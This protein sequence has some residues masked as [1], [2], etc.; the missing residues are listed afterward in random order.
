MMN[1]AMFFERQCRPH[2][3]GRDDHRQAHCPVLVASDRLKCT[4]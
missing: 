4:L 2:E 3:M 1:W